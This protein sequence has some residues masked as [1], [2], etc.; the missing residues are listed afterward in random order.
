MLGGVE[1]PYVRGLAG[2]S[3]ADVL[4]HAVMDALL[5]AAGLGD[6][7]S[8]FPDTDEHWRDADSIDLL[9]RV[10]GMLDEQGLEP[11]NVDAIVLCEAPKLGPFRDAMRERAGRRARPR[12]LR[13]ECEVHDRRGHGLR[14]PRRG[15]RARSGHR[16]RRR[17]RLRL[18]AVQS[19]EGWIARTSHS[20]ARPPC[21]DG[22]R[23]TGVVPRAGGALPRPHRPA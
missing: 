2:H 4:T 1:V 21:A 3:D 14:G 12:R 5:G 23:G 9:S 15:H 20:P 19:T 10:R 18:I 16:N 22:A 11:V 8:H 7:G 13:R 6:I 17:T